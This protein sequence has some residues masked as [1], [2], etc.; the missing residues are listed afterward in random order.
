[1]VNKNA[2]LVWDGILETLEPDSTG[3]YS[4]R[5]NGVVV[6]NEDAAD[7]S[8]VPEP[9]RNAFKEVSEDSALCWAS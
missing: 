8:T 5:W 9:P 1:M 6:A 2:V 7:A 3:G 4:L